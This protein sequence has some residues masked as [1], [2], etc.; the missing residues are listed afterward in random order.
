VQSKSFYVER[1]FFFNGGPGKRTNVA[2]T[3]KQFLKIEIKLINKRSSENS[4]LREGKHSLIEAQNEP[5]APILPN[6]RL[7]L[8]HNEWRPKDV[9]K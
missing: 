5:Y 9:S 6:L 2:S 4:K 8:Q 3:K 7:A 1:I